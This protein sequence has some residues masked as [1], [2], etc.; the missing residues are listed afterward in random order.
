MTTAI[1]T[2]TEKPTAIT[3]PQANVGRELSMYGLDRE[4]VALIKRTVAARATDDQLALF[5]TTAKR[6]GLDPFAKQIYCVVRDTKDGPVMA[7][8]TEEMRITI[9]A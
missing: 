4:Q 7:I 6:T 5:L 1:A 3:A 8:Q 9:S 2:T